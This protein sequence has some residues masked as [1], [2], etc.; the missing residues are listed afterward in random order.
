MKLTKQIHINKRLLTLCLGLLLSAYSIATHAA[1]SNNW[2]EVSVAIFKHKNSATG[3]ETWPPHE[4][5]ELSY[6]ENLVQ[7]KPS[8]GS[9]IANEDSIEKNAITVPSLDQLVAFKESAPSNQ[10]FKQ[11][12]ASIKR[13]SN[14]QLLK[15][16]TWQQP[17]LDKEQAIPVQIQAGAQ[18]DEYHE[19]EGSLELAVSRFLH[20]KANLWLA[21]YIQKIET[22]KPW[23][24]Q[25]VFLKQGDNSTP[26]TRYESNQYPD[27]SNEE[28][29][30]RY[31]SQRTVVLNESRRM[32]SSEL[33]YL[34]NPLFGILVKVT[35]IKEQEEVVQDVELHSED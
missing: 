35:P 5:L 30:S 13:S 24:Q 26:D 3:N 10:D 4:G 23:W 14:Y 33:H 25:D 22:A 28:T 32:R 8:S 6:P 12:L 31:E 18:F 15:S 11:A 29:V 20:L 2:Y 7:L 9:P 17:A 27:Y 34:D 19:L 1:T 21:D 16:I